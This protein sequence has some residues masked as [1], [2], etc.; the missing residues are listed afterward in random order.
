[1]RARASCEWIYPPERGSKSYLHRRH[2]FCDGTAIPARS[3]RE[4]D[5]GPQASTCLGQHFRRVGTRG[6]YSVQTAS[7]QGPVKSSRVSPVLWIG[8]ANDPIFNAS[9]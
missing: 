9:V 8:G 7:I 5:A 6:T 1:M 2:R 4:P 3:I